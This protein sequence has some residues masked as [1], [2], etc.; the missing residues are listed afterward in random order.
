ME[1]G[2]G[3]KT[4]KGLVKEHE[5]TWTRVWGLTVGLWSELGGGGQRGKLGQL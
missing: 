5:W 3:G 2:S 4:G 1:G